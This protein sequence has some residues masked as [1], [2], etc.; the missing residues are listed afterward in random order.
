M[1]GA[2][3]LNYKNYDDTID[4]VEQLKKQLDADD[5]IY[6]VDNRSPNNSLAILTETFQDDANVIVID[7]GKNGG[8]SYGNNVGFKAAIADGCRELLCTNNDIQFYDNCISELR[9]CLRKNSDVAVVGPKVYTA[10][11]DIQHCNKTKLTPFRFIMSFK[12]LYNLDIFGVNK[13][14]HMMSYQYDKEIAFW[15]MTSGC[16]FLIKATVL[17]EIGFLDENVFLYFEE[18]ILARKL[19]D[20]KYKT[21]ITPKAEIMHYGSGTIGATS[22]FMHFHKF[23]SGLYYLWNYTKISKLRLK[24]IGAWLRFIFFMVS[25]KNSEYK[26]YRKELKQYINALVLTERSGL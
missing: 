9:S 26:R 18:D 13:R 10:T 19:R 11:G 12:P 5:K 25:I 21:M 16:C 14:Y 8:F 6:I 7:S 2:V 22:P 15:G 20:A 24:M 3:V 23:K 1:L 4:C 17:E